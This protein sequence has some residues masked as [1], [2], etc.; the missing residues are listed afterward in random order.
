L[1]IR[2]FKEKTMKL[3]LPLDVMHPYSNLLQQTRRLLPLEDIDIVILYVAENS[4]QHESILKKLGKSASELDE[5]V[6]AQS[7]KILE[8]AA[9]ELRPLCNSI[10]LQVSSGNPAQVINATAQKEQCELIVINSADNVSVN[11]YVLGSTSSNVVKHA[12]VPVLVVRSSATS[13]QELKRVLIG[14]DG[15]KMALTALTTFARQFKAAS[16]KLEVVVVNVVSI[17]GIWKFISPIEFIAAVEDN[18]DMSAQVILAEADKALSDV[19]LK[20]TDLVVRSGN[21]ALELM[22][23]AEDVKADLIVVG[24]QGKAPLES[25]LLGSVS[26]KLSLHSQVATLIVR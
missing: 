9:K 25:F 15:S 6:K 26:N 20:P 3:L 18:M 13:S 14:V 24:A 19:G 22:K 5:Q 23:T 2:E 10:S 21:P 16:R 4:Q 17:A 11:T 1:I 8:E 7:H 12:S